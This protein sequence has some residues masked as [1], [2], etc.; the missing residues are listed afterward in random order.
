MVI[1]VYGFRVFLCFLA[2]SIYDLWL[3][4][5]HRLVVFRF[6]SFRFLGILR[7]KF[8][9]RLFGFFFVLLSFRV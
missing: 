7:I 5:A 3:Y 1:E 2:F 6:T 4:K 8:F 9:L